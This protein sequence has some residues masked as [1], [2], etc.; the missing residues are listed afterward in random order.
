M[1]Y[2]PGRTS[3]RLSIAVSL[4]LGGLV[5]PIGAETYVEFKPDLPVGTK[6][7]IDPAVLHPTQTMVGMREVEMR[8]AQ[9]KGW[10]VNRRERFMQERTAPIVIG[11]G[12]EVYL[13]DHHH[14]A[15]MLLQSKIL[16]TMYVEIKGNYAAL[17]EQD[18]WAMMEKRQWVYLFDEAGHVLKGP[19][20]LPK[21]ILD[22]RDDPYRS[23]AWLVRERG[24]YKQVKVLY[25]EF[26]WANYFR[27]RIKIEGGEEGYQR[28][29]AAALPL[30]HSPQA[31]DL[32]GY[33]AP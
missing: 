6:C 10:S 15:L 3:I 30:C 25:Q 17:S 28:A 8:T 7:L 12:N 2:S 29:V 24:G 19:S 22:L 14:L 9:L 27:S 13:L 26:L 21:R 16:P 31:R 20:Q 1:K 33:I 32:P 5:L 23:L 4:L 11:P 18:F